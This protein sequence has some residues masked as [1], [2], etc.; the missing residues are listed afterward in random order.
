MTTVNDGIVKRGA[1]AGT[2]AACE[3]TGI[4]SQRLKA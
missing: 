1:A 3:K 4:V 2:P